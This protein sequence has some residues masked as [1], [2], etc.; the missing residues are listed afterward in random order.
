[1]KGFLVSVIALVFLVLFVSVWGWIAYDLWNFN[2][3]PRKMTLE[4]DARVV[5]VAG[6]LAATVAA[7]T[8]AFLGI[9]IQKRPPGVSFTDWLQSAQAVR[10]A[11]L[12]AGVLAYLGIGGLLFALWL[13]EPEEATPDFI[14]AFA[15]A[16]LAGQLALSQPSSLRREGRVAGRT[17]R[18]LPTTRPSGATFPGRPAGR[19]TAA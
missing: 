5:E 15:W 19:I 12:A 4:V 2:P 9:E 10:A 7:G 18:T 8:A 17:R 1:M 16:S 13:T 11:L 14:S 3:S 6:F